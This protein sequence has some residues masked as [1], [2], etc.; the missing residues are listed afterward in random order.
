[1]LWR[2]T[3]I[4]QVRVEVDLHKLSLREVGRRIFDISTEK[5]SGVSPKT[6]IGQISTHTCDRLLISPI[7]D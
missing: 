6:R 1:M 7:Q 4:L 2:E 3:A 5:L